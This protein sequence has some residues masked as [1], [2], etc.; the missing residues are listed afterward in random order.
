M[1]FGLGTG[2]GDGQR[3]GKGLGRTGAGVG[4]SLGNLAGKSVPHSRFTPTTPAS[5]L[6]PKLYPARQDRKPSR[7][8][9]RFH[10]VLPKSPPPHHVV[11]SQ[12]CP[13]EQDFSR[14]TDQPTCHRPCHP[15]PCP[16]SS[17]FY[18]D[19]VAQISAQRVT[20]TTGNK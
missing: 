6:P 5:G 17:S 20:A 10:A 4:E 15:S 9:P 7:D 13:G 11:M 3:W 14:L 19:G 1:L 2:S 18:S 12:V 16:I 8:A